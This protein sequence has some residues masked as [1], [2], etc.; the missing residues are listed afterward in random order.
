MFSYLLL[1]LL[2]ITSAFSVCAQSGRPG[3]PK[4][5]VT[6]PSDSVI[7]GDI[8]IFSVNV[9]DYDYTKLRYRWTVSAGTIER[10]ANTPSVVVRTMEGGVESLTA[11]VEIEGLPSHCAATS[12]KTAPVQAKCGTPQPVGTYEE[13]NGAFERGILSTIIEKYKALKS[14]HTILFTLYSQNKNEASRQKKREREILRM[15]LGLGY[16]R[17]RFV[18]VHSDKKPYATY[19]YFVPKKC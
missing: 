18:F 9:A 8:A 14:E 4:I 17:D 12:S 1:C 7:A 15:L 10:G 13:I 5:D 2:I 19:I 11:T 3:C 6:G 16:T